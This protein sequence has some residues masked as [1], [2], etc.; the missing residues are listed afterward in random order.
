LKKLIAS[1]DGSEA[2]LRAAGDSAR[3]GDKYEETSPEEA[4]M[5]AFQR[6]MQRRP[7]QLARYDYA[8]E[9]L[10][11]S[12]GAFFFIWYFITEYSSYFIIIIFIA[13]V[14]SPPPCACGS[15]R[16]FELQLMPALLTHLRAS[17]DVAAGVSPPLDWCTAAVFSCAASCEASR[18]E[19][20][21]VLGEDEVAAGVGG[22][23]GGA[24]AHAVAAAPP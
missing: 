20:I 23:G 3:L 18:E 21:V 9:P 2:A 6:R 11:C 5:L 16:C 15:P 19:H 12:A 1:D 14:P 24:A 10:W 13:P 4:A 7:A 17:V 8:G 22:G